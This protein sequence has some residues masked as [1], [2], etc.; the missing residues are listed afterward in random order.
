MVGDLNS[1]RGVGTCL[2]CGSPLSHLRRVENERFCGERCRWRYATL[3]PHQICAGCGTPL[4]PRE[5]GAR[6]CASPGCLR[7]VEELKRGLERRRLESLREKAGE[8]RDREAAVLGV[9]EPET[10]T[11]TVLPSSRARVTNLPERRRRA[12]RS[13]V[14]R[15]ISAASERLTA[16]PPG[17]AGRPSAPASSVAPAPEVQPVL[18]GACALCQ[19]FCCGNGGNHAYLTVETIRRYMARHPDL[20]PRDVLA[21][22]LGRV[23]NKTY[24]GSCLFHQP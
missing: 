11:P 5:F 22:Y 17:G 19:G 3:P 18:G 10:Y 21:A 23:G 24:E 4:S 1:F 12:F 8:L 13:A 14:N 2:F 7:R 20:R 16:P 6:A 15:L 9:P